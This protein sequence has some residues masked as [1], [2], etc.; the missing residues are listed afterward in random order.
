MLQGIRVYD[1]LLFCE[2]VVSE[3]W[4]GVGFCLY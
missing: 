1:M 3:I 2:W 4:V